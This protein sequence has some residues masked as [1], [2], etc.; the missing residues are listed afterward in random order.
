MR[1]I[2][3]FDLFIAKFANALLT[4]CGAVLTPIFKI[5]TFSGNYGLIF[6]IAAICLCV[7]KKTR[8]VGI[9]ALLALCSGFL[10]TNVALKNIVARERPFIGG[11]ERFYDFWL[12]AGALKESGYS[13]PSGHTTSAA[14][15]S[16]AVL[17]TVKKRAAAFIVLVPVIMGFTRI[18]FGVH[19]ASDIVGGIVVGAVAALLALLIAYFLKRL[20]IRKKS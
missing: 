5:I 9:T 16:I 14:A 6:I 10:F 13:F 7:F 12:Q 18:Y 19:Y 4:K 20:L 8:F 3:S 11:G 2:Y 1:F 15:F 17:L